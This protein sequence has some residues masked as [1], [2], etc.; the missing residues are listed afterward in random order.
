LY[1]IRPEAEKI[2]G[3]AEDMAVAGGWLFGVMSGEKVSFARG[4]GPIR[5]CLGV[6][7]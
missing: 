3:R 2:S 6:D 7:N 5:G 4:W 1:A